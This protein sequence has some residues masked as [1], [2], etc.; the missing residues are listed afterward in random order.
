MAN[1][2]NSLATGA[3]KIAA[4]RCLYFA[5]FTVSGFS[6]LIYES[7]W[8]HYLK[9]FLGHAAYAQ[10]LVLIIFM[11]GMAAGSWLASR[12]SQ[13]CRT[14]IL[15]YAAVEAVVGV[16][17]LLFHGLF[18]NLIGIFYADILPAIGM[19]VVGVTLKWLA[20]SILIM[21]QSILLG[22]TFPLMS[23]GIIRRFPGMPGGS[24]AMLYF[25]NSIGAS[26]GVLA[27]GF[28]LI[29]SVG[30]PG[31]MM[32]AGL[33]NI[34]LALIVWILLRLDP[35]PESK[36]LEVA[37]A[38]K[39]EP[40]L[41]KLFLIA[42]FITGAASFIYEIGWIR[43]LSLV[44]GATTHSFELMLSAFILGL[45]FGGLWIKRRIDSISEPVFFSGV[46][47]IV[48]GILAITTIPI[49]MA[50][51][52][53]MT[54]LLSALGRNGA[55]FSA[56]SL[57]SH[58][59]AL[60]VMLPTTFMAGMTL[61]LFTFTLLKRESGE[62]S[63]GR[64]Y[65]ANTVGAIAGVLFAV[66]IG[67]P[68]LGLKDLIIFG[69]A[70]DI[71]LG[72]V[73]LHRVSST[74]KNKS[75]WRP[76]IGLI[77][78]AGVAGFALIADDFDTRKLISG[79]F[80][81]GHTEAAEQDEILFYKDGKTAS[82]SLR[83]TPDDNIILATNGKVDAAIQMGESTLFGV[84]EATM[85]LAGT[86]PL[87]FRPDATRVANIGMG[88]GQTTHVLLGNPNLISVDTIEIEPEMVEA[89]KGF[90]AAVERA[91]ND[92]RSHIHIEDAKTY[93][94]IH[95]SVYDIIVAEPSNPWV[96]GVASLFSTEFY[97][98]VKNYLVPGGLFVQWI[99]LYE[100]SDELAQSI[101]KALI[102][103]FPDFVIYAADTSN[104]LL[105]ATTDGELGDPAW[106]ILEHGE[107]AKSL[108]RIGVISAADLQFRKIA[109]ATDVAPYLKLV[110]TPVNSDYYPYVDLNAGAARFA[111][112][113][114]V[115]FKDWLN[116]PV[117]M[118]EMLHDEAVEYREITPVPYLARSESVVVARWILQKLREN[119]LVD[120]I[121]LTGPE[122]DRLSYLVDWLILGKE[123]CAIDANRERWQDT[124]FEIASIT[125]PYL[126]AADGRNLV[127]LIYDST[128]TVQKLHESGLWAS[129]Y[130]A[131][132]GR[133]G[134]AMSEIA[135]RMLQADI[136]L[137]QLR[138][139]YLIAAAML[140]SI[141]SGDPQRAYETWASSGADQLRGATL[142]S[143]LKL[144]LSI[145]VDST[146]Q[147]VISIE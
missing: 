39:S 145:A 144:L 115:L 25:T 46:V 80:R 116:A 19:P 132:A 79:V 83:Q 60:A 59:I 16:V 56:Y 6:G 107:L 130:Q 137:N 34:L 24:I 33:L 147:N 131:V 17:A 113:W 126:I 143:H 142:G 50:T 139:E 93:F 114:A 136:P 119:S 141:S 72:I 20:A 117:P 47:Q 61:P 134:R 81:Y 51:F 54:F 3:I 99:Q 9:L 52:D 88:S 23:A 13:G 100:F 105:V 29:K 133:D 42:A 87:A 90:G 7:I 15:I 22:M 78:G 123:N 70:L 43:M 106:E 121:G 53:W 96:S 103:N 55:A 31:T 62:A 37:E 4:P 140:G 49:Y 146:P 101:L 120:P 30:L 94:S 109:T 95:N 12:F 65:A 48:M 32:T 118:L 44:L 102:Q 104:I 57:A 91:H 125:L 14:P 21:P 64:I 69:A 138:R 97:K 35:Q 92:P 5:I 77:V 66:H 67:M 18:T 10:S 71:G 89:S 84:D 111:G 8:S 26:I 122:V 63:I 41:Q 36:P 38:G 85:T 110:S 108:A 76:V 128:C 68:I 73:L 40:G 1:S 112:S 2:G 27:S 129:L 135:G 124:V 75:G 28:W 11:G 127:D 58:L 82:V 45:A 86:L 74:Q 98:T